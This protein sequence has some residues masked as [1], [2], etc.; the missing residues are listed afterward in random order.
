METVSVRPV[1]FLKETIMLGQVKDVLRDKGFFFILADG[2]DYFAHRDDL[3]G[4]LMHDIQVGMTVSFT[5]IPDAPR[6]PRAA[7]ICRP[8]DDDLNGLHQLRQL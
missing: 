3:R 2:R 7:D 4:M 5:A 6:G 1:V 8:S